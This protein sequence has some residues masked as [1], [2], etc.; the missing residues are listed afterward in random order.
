MSKEEGV[1]AV[2]TIFLILNVIS[3]ICS[4]FQPLT[5]EAFSNIIIN[6]I[7][8]ATFSILLSSI[9]TL[10]KM[11]LE[12]FKFIFGLYL[13]Y[14]IIH[15]IYRIIRAEYYYYDN[16]F[17]FTGK[18]GTMDRKPKKYIKVYFSVFG[19]SCLILLFNYYISTILYI[20]EL[21]EEIKDEEKQRNLENG[22]NGNV[23][24]VQNTEEG[25]NI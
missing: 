3:L 1:K 8:I 20:N 6:I 5:L 17:Y 23:E 18:I 7:L 11:G 9:K 10:N 25:Q 4:F 21:L 14:S 15:L 2:T 24:S 16:D 12:Q 19:I 13:L 22:N